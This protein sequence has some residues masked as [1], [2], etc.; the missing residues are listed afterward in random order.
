M[1]RRLRRLWR[2]FFPA[3]ANPDDA[4]AL[5]ELRLEEAHLYRAM[6]PRDREH[7]VWVARRLLERYPEAPGFAVRAALLHDCGKALR[8]YHPLERVLTSLLRLDVPIEPLRK[9]LLG[10]WQIRQHH[11]EYGAARILDPQVA[12]IVREH[13]RPESLWAR[14]LYEVDEEF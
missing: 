12:Q 10:A 11:P 9:G 7:A 13:H 4:W 3:R 5:S 1:W 6:D 2:A 14:R 8:P